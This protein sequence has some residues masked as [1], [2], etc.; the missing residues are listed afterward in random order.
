MRRTPDEIQR[1]INETRMLLQENLDDLQRKLSPSELIEEAMAYYRRY[2]GEAGRYVTHTAREHPISLTMTGIGLGLLAY[3]A[4]RGLS[5]G[6]RDSESDHPAYQKY[7]ARQGATT[8]GQPVGGPARND[9]FGDAEDFDTRGDLYPDIRGGAG[10]GSTSS[11]RG[12]RG[13]A[14]A[15][16]DEGRRRYEQ[17]RHGVESGYDYARHGVEDGYRSARAGVRDGY[18]SASE[19]VRDGYRQAWHAT[20][21]AVRYARRQARDAG[22]TAREFVRDE[23]LLV[24]AIGLAVGALLGAALPMT[25]REHRAI[26]RESDAFREQVKSAA[27]EGYHRAEHVAEASYDAAKGEARR[28]GFSSEGAKAAAESLERKTAAVYSAATDTAKKEAEKEA[29]AATSSSSSSSAGSSS[30]TGNGSARK[31]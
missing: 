10:Y 23:P 22:S 5:S 16:A 2:P 13:Y 17:A 27:R 4:A 6:G 19:G 18:K 29:S 3:A 25:R 9:A 30:G 7:G 24:G 31:S 26:G 1:D 12:P 14:D 8:F 11:R 28:Q 21:D 20:E 15:V